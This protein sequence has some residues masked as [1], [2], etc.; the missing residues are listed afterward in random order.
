MPTD[1]G[2]SKPVGFDSCI[3]ANVPYTKST[4][5][6]RRENTNGEIKLEDLRKWGTIYGSN[7]LPSNNECGTIFRKI[8]CNNDHSHKPAFKHIYCNDPLCPKCYPKFSA[9]ISER[10]TEQIQGFKDVYPDEKV[11]HLIF[12][13]VKGMVYESRDDAFKDAYRMLKE[14]HAKAAAVFYHPSRIRDEIKP[15]LRRIQ[16]QQRDLGKPTKG[17]WDMAHKDVLGLGVIENYYKPGPHF[18]APAAGYLENSK[19]YSERTGAGYKKRGYL[20][21]IEDIHKLAF[22]LATHA[23]Y[24]AGKDTVR[25]W[26]LMSKYQLKRY[27]ACERIEDVECE[28]CRSTM[29]EYIYDP[30]RKE[31]A[32][33]PILRVVTRKIKMWGYYKRG[34]YVPKPSERFLSVSEHKKEL[35]KMLDK[36]RAAQNQKLK[37]WD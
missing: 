13:P 15:A 17:F 22:Y 16:K 18:H 11:Y 3:S 36:A 31:M 27:L 2:E 19:T 10:V 12:W 25:Y 34:G 20:G 1:S 7:F 5:N 30:V 35:R 28:V 29:A 9:R 6:N 14:M 21:S 8:V 26:G 24:E 37:G 4:S 32:K 23:S 33:D